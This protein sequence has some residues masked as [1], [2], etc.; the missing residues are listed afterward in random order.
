[1]RRVAGRCLEQLCELAGCVAR[2]DLMHAGR[3]LLRLLERAQRQANQ[4]AAD[5]HD[6][7]GKGQRR[8]AACGKTDPALAAHQE[9]FDLA[10]ILNRHRERHERRAAGEVDDRDAVAGVMQNVVG[11]DL[12]RLQV[13]REQLEILGAEPSQQIVP[14]PAGH[15]S[16]L[17]ALRW[18]GIGVSGK[19]PTF[20]RRN[21]QFQ[22]EHKCLR[23]TEKFA[24]ARRR[25]VRRC[26]Q[27]TLRTLFSSGELRNFQ[28]SQRL[29]GAAGSY[30]RRIWRSARRRP[31]ATCLR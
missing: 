5:L 4:R 17:W 29:W 28:M 13:R 9:T 24:A 31:W 14:G 12:D 15:A 18:P 22:S 30:P 19:N 3:S 10:V 27:D 20:P 23:E 8:A 7:A 16:C 11:S 2:K 26:S 21:R 25:A 1:M 6:D